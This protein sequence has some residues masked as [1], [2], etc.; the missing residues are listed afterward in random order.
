MSIGR[1]DSSQL[2]QLEDGTLI[3]VASSEYDSRPISSGF[4]MQ[5]DGSLNKIAPMIERACRPVLSAL[6]EV[7][8][9]EG[10]IS[11][12]EIEI[13]FNLEPEGNV[14]IAQ[15]ANDASIKVK[16]IVERSFPS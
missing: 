4:A 12:A 16:L 3:E 14:Y 1:G 11:K 5:V 13:G 10:E 8:S 7:R 6:G 2:I 15:V 9:G